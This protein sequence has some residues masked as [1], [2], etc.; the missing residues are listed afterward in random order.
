MP[1]S[2]G[3]VCSTSGCPNLADGRFCTSCDPAKDPRSA[4]NHR[5]VS[6]QARCHGAA[7]DALVREL[8]GQPCGLRYAGCTGEATGADLV[9]PRSRGGLT[10]RE[11]ARPACGHCQSVQ[12]GRLTRA[13]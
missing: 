8:R 2:A 6:R 12:G 3:R 1:I 5:G 10:T 9:V 11:N 13:G 4:R 7:Y